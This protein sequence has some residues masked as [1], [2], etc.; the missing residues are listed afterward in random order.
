M[1]RI[2]RSLWLAAAAALIALAAGW[3]VASTTPAPSPAAA[4]LSLEL[5]DPLAFSPNGVLFVGDSEAAAIY[6]LETRAGAP[7]AAGQELP[8]IRD[9]D[10]KLAAF[11]GTTARDVAVNDMAVHPTDKSVYLSLT[12]GRGE[13]AKPALVRVD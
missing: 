9:F 6:A 5:A 1:R 4:A 3:A 10:E 7:P 8:S 13:A 12:R 2:S 11:L